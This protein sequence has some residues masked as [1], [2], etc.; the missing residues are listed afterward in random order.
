MYLAKPNTRNNTRQL[1]PCEV[2]LVAMQPSSN[3]SD[4]FTPLSAS[5][6]LRHCLEAQLSDGEQ[7]PSQ[8]EHA[9]SSDVAR[10]RQSRSEIEHLAE[11]PEHLDGVDPVLSN[12]ERRV[13]IP[14]GCANT[15]V[16]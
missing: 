4:S 15:S 11:D 12:G 6:S 10:S 16:H 14:S 13:G 3:Y 7:I 2:A 1:L 9:S 8:L 5:P